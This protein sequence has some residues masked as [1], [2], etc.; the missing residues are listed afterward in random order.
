MVVNLHE[1]KRFKEKLAALIE[2]AEDMG[3]DEDLMEAT[4]ETLSICMDDVDALIK[5]KKKEMDKEE[6]SGGFFNKIKEICPKYN[7][8]YFFTISVKFPNGKIPKSFERV[9]TARE[10]GVITSSC[11]WD[12][13]VGKDV[14]VLTKWLRA[15][16]AQFHITR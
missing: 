11:T 9:F 8:E 3:I 12:W 15:K 2:E 7:G 10:D 6:M 4:A 16:E 1:L 5:K 14:S 13:I